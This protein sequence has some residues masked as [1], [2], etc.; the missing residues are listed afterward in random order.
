MALCLTKAGAAQ[1]ATAIK[2]R[3]SSTPTDFACSAIKDLIGGEPAHKD[4]DSGAVAFFW[5]C[6]KWYADFVGENHDDTEV[7]GGF[8]DNTLGMYLVRGIAF[9]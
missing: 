6:I 2:A 1:L 4:V 3:V 8:W 7:N 5:S 9:G